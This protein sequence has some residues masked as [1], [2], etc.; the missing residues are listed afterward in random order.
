MESTRDTIRLQWQYC[1]G[2]Q[3][4]SSWFTANLDADE[5]RAWDGDFCFV[6]VRR[7][8][9]DPQRW[10]IESSDG[11]L[12]DDADAHSFASPADAVDFL[13]QHHRVTYQFTDE[14]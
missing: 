11:R 10:R 3:D 4:I 14:S 7:D 13:A 12:P 6:A 1:R 2:E 8:G 9:H 5:V